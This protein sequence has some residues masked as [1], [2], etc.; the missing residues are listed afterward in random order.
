ME[1]GL[2]DIELVELV[3]ETCATNFEK[4]CGLHPISG[5]L[6][7]RLKYPNPLSLPRRIAPDRP[8]IGGLDMRPDSHQIRTGQFLVSGRDHSTLDVVLQFANIAGPGRSG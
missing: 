1:A 5:R 6:L 2:T 8:Q 3:I 4:T 7:Q